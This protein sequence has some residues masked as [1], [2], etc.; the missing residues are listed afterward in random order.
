[1]MTILKRDLIKCPKCNLEQIALVLTDDESAIFYH[2][3]RLCGHE[4]EEPEWTPVIEDFDNQ[5]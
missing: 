5:Q 3:C 1:M 2:E 4:I